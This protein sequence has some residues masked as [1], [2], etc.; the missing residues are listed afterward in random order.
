MIMTAPENVEHAVYLPPPPPPPYTHTLNPY[1]NQLTI[2]FWQQYTRTC[3]YVP[4]SFSIYLKCTCKYKKL[5]NSYVWRA[6]TPISKSISIS[7]NNTY[8][9][10]ES[11]LIQKRTRKINT[12]CMNLNNI[13]LVSL[14]DKPL[15]FDTV[16]SPNLQIKFLKILRGKPETLH[17]HEQ[18]IYNKY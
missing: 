15:L 6:I 7:N 14:H 1:T 11:I 2:F 8:T 18:M 9:S 5:C 10:I 17:V 4:Q 3:I 16:F 12:L 13:F